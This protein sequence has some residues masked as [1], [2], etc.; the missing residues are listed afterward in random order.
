MNRLTG[1]SGPRKGW[2]RKPPEAPAPSGSAGEGEPREEP[3]DGQE[4]NQEEG[5]YKAR[6][7]LIA[8]GGGNA[9]GQ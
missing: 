4:G 5:V 1:E 8:R 6:G 2:G 7:C 9:L 3:P